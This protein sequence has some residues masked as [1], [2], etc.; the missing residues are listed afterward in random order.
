MAVRRSDLMGQDE[1][2][3]NRGGGRRWEW[4]GVR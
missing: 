4:M 3:V 2:E 1:G